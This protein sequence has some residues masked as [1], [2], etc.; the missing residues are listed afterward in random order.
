MYWNVTELTFFLIRFHD[1]DNSQLHPQFDLSKTENEDF[2]IKM[3]AYFIF[4]H[5]N[6]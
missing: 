5:Y 6:K 2:L 1:T 4:K 3:A